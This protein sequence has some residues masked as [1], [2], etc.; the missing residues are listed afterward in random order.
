MD[1]LQ[2]RVSMEH[3]GCY[4]FRFSDVAASG[5]STSGPVA[6]PVANGYG[7]GLQVT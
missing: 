6:N 4:A 5:S 1:S 2:S 3:M 7:N